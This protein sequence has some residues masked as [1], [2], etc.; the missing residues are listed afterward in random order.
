MTSWNDRLF[1]CSTQSKMSTNILDHVRTLAVILE[2]KFSNGGSRRAATAP[3]KATGGANLP[4][5]PTFCN[6]R[7]NPNE[8]YQA[9]LACSSAKSELQR[10]KASPENVHDLSKSFCQANSNEI[11]RPLF[12]LPL[13]AVQS[14]RI[15]GESSR[16]WR[17]SAAAGLSI[18]IDNLPLRADYAI[19]DYS[20]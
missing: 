11:E 20:R 19:I 15:S 6:D 2:A 9:K 5:L 17:C 16:T 12:L 18:I 8:R 3:T 1:A 14:R 10:S 7:W 4:L 13:R